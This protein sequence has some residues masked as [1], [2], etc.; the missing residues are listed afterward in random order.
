MLSA[1]VDET[2]QLHQLMNTER[3]KN[4]LCTLILGDTPE[5][6]STG[7]NIFEGEG[8]EVHLHPL[9][10]VEVT[11]TLKPEKVLLLESISSANDIHKSPQQ[12]A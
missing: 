9:D 8:L 6:P 5:P 4:G 3:S 12:Q 2:A 10:N 7:S 11:L 1:R